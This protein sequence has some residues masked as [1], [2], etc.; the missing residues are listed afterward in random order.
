V[1]LIEIAGNETFLH[2][3]AGGSR[4]V[5]RVG[6]EEPRPDVGSTVRIGADAKHLYL[7]DAA[8]G[9]SRR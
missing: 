1:E 5:A 2:L 4:F 8:T 9:E 7:F 6:S 3:D